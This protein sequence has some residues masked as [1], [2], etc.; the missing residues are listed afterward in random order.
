VIL[1]DGR[2]IAYGYCV[3]CTGSSYKV[4]WKVSCESIT[5]L[6]E[7][8]EYLQSQRELY[9]QAKNILCI[10]AGAVGV[11]V[12][13]EICS[14][15]PSKRVTL[16]NSGSV[17][18]ASAPGNLGASAQIILSNIPSLSLISNELALSNDGKHYQTNKSKTVI[19]ADLVYQCVGITPNTEF[20]H[21]THPQWLNEKKFIKVDNFLKASDEV[22]AIGDVN[23]SDD[24]KMFF[25]A[26]MQAVH[27]ARN[28][29]RILKGHKPIP[30]KGSRPA[31]VVSLG[32]NHAVGYVAGIS[33]TGWPFN[34]RQGSKLASISKGMIERITMDDL[35]LEKPTNR[36]LYYTHEKGQLIPQ[37]L[38]KICLP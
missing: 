13:S 31:M 21:Q 5:S 23:G 9:K 8:F 33:L 20:L 15:D 2:E 6:E 11:E 25:N 28:I 24:P 17:A 38:A 26:H 7:R 3:I 37:I 22:F 16:I 12:A 18:L 36:V 19:T 30:Y 29:Q 4:P 35:Y 32:P 14:R 34:R 10:G 1:H 27:T